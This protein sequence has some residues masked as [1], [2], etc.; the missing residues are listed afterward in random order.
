MVMVNSSSSQ[1]AKE[2]KI[3]IKKTAIPVILRYLPIRL[4]SSFLF[5]ILYP[6][7]F[8]VK[9]S[10]VTFFIVTAAAGTYRNQVFFGADIGIGAYTAEPD[11]SPV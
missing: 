5:L 3:R 1:K 7:V 9:L 6:V 4:P 11:K 10:L 2:D 8:V